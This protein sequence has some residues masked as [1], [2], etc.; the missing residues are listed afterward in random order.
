[1]ANE[2]YQVMIRKPGP[3]ARTRLIDSLLRYWLDEVSGKPHADRHPLPSIE[4]LRSL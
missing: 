4:E 1:M 3:E 2:E